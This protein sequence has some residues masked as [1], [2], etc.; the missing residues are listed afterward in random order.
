MDT[1]DHMLS[2]IFKSPTTILEELGSRAKAAR[3]VL[4]WTRKTLAVKSGVPEPT[5]KRFEL[6]GKIGTAALVNMAIALDMIDKLDALFAPK[7]IQFIA[8]VSA[9]KRQRGSL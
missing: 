4:G 1:K 3:L 7:P 2:I 9:K 5:I 6:T 8:D